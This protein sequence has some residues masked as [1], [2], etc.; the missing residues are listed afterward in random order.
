MKEEVLGW[1]NNVSDY[2]SS[3]QYDAVKAINKADEVDDK[4]SLSNKIEAITLSI[5]AIDHQLGKL[6]RELRG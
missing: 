1:L 5:Q 6:I 2:L 3:A 4:G